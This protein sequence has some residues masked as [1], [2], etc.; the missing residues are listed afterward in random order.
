MRR[1]RPFSKRMREKLL[2]V[3]IAASQRCRTNSPGADLGAKRCRA[4]KHRTCFITPHV[5]YVHS[6]SCAPGSLLS[7]RSRRFAHTL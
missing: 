7:G 1:L 6:G 2:R 3:P 5:L 4:V